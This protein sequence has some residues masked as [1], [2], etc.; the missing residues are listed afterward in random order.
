VDK[1]GRWKVEECLKGETACETFRLAFNYS[2]PLTQK[3]NGI[4]VNLCVDNIKHL[5]KICW[6]LL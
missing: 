4:K 1:W 2:C 5:F 3:S 6:S